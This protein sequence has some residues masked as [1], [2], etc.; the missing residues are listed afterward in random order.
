[1]LS[2]SALW[3]T[4]HAHYVLVSRKYAP[5]RISPPPHIF[6]VKFC[7]GIFIPRISP[8]SP[9]QTIYDHYHVWQ[10]CVEIE[11]YPVAYFDRITVFEARYPLKA[12][13][14]A[15]TYE[16]FT[17]YGVATRQNVWFLHGTATCIENILP[18]SNYKVVKCVVFF[19]L[20]MKLWAG[21]RKRG[22]NRERKCWI[23]SI[24][25]PVLCTKAKVAKGGVYSRDTMVLFLILAE[26]SDRFQIL[27]SYTLLS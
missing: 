1:M 16:K 20:D 22:R 5:P 18:D 10:F 11:G 7:R 13:S 4:H 25:P 14:F 9:P 17:R 23:S 2:N 27:Q 24:S 15:I 8:P 19:Y 3:S 21:H 12:G 6:R 26:N